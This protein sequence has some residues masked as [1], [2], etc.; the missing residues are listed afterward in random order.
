[1]VTSTKEKRAIYQAQYSGVRK[2]GIVPRYFA[3]EVPEAVQTDRV[4]RARLIPRS[5]TAFLQ[6]DPLP[7]CSAGERASI[8]SPSIVHD[9]LD[10][11]IFR[12]VSLV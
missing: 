7:G 10:D 1:M 3:M 4:R 5:L 12:R 8:K 11:L 6:G 9:A 2:P